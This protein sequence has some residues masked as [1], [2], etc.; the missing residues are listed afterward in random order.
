MAERGEIRNLDHARQLV[1]FKGMRWGTITPTDI[2]GFI[3]FRNRLFIF[4]E[5]KYG[6]EPVPMGQRIALERLCKN[7]VSDNRTAC[8]LIVRHNVKGADIEVAKMPGSE[9]YYKGE[10]KGIKN[11][12]S[13][14][15]FKLVNWLI[16]DAGLAF[17]TTA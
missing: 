8:A 14:T 11:P 6:D 16:K 3:D 5:V 15:T 10:W 17:T 12:D 13:Y 2:D 4:L 9:I 7:S 1:L